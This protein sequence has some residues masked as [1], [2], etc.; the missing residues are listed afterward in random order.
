L[1]TKNKIILFTTG[2]IGSFAAGSALAKRKN[3]AE[4]KEYN[5]K[6]KDSNHNQTIYEK[7]VKKGLDKSLSFTG[8]V[9]L[10]PLYAITALAI[11]ID[12]PGPVLFTQKRVGKDKQYFNLHKF[13][14]MKMST[15]HDVPTHMLEN[16]ENYI[17]RVGKVLRKTS[18]DELPQ[19]WNIFRGRMSVIGPRPALWNQDD[20]VA[21][22]D[23]YGANDV[24]PGL[25]GWAQINGRDE[26]EI[27]V[28]AKLDGE[29]VKILRQ[30][31]FRALFFDV[32]CFVRTITSVLKHDGVVEGGT[33]SLPDPTD[34]VQSKITRG[35]LKQHRF[36]V[37]TKYAE[38]KP[39]SIL[40]ICQYYYPEPFRIPDICEELV[41]R[42]H[43][44]MVITGWPNYPDGYLYEG[45]QGNEDRRVHQDEI[46]NGVRVHRC[47]TVPR[48]TGNVKRLLNYYSYA[49]SSTAY[50]KSGKALTKDGK[51]F[52]VVFCNQLSPIM[53][54]EAAI[55]YKKKY[56][57]PLVFYCLDIWPESLVAG[58]VDRSSPIYKLFHRVSGRIYKASDALL[59]TSRLFIDYLGNQFGIEKNS[60]EYL[61]QYAEGIFEPLGLKENNG[62]TDLMF[63]GNIGKSHSLDTV[64]RAAEILKDEKIRFHIVGSGSDLERIKLLAKGKKLE[65]IIFYGRRPLEEMPDLYRS[66]DAMLIT[67]KIDPV[68]SNTLPGKVQTYMACGKPIIG[69]IDGETAKVIKESGCGYCGP[70]EDSQTLVNNIRKLRDEA[71][72]YELGQKSIDYY[73]INFSKVTFMD[74]LETIL[75]NVQHHKNAK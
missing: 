29:Y 19:I 39:K 36:A 47:W 15:P 9:V 5:I 72:I 35:G 55:A 69:A 22:R 67:L 71:N 74:Q 63:A 4:T 58:G 32:K 42:G 7:Y 52:D 70:A 48:E 24:L 8:L 12:D 41:K 43:E 44:V 34:D 45:Y 40:V 61:P 27:P 18:L 11:F 25:T 60:I 23:K 65:N 68:L 56:H 16:P 50:V 31:G 2:L 64:I 10:S 66:A 14:S 53:M 3:D 46:I 17:T 75:M 49:A 38:E 51:P 13:R 20:L 30:G 21:E 33:G 73:N 59:V 62:Y 54:A 6:Q 1:K 28:K 26:L 57:V 37:D